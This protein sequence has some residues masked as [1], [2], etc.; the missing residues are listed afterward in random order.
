MVI[1]DPHR[2]ID[3]ESARLVA[4]RIEG[5]RSVAWMDQTHLI[6]RVDSAERRSMQMIDQVCDALDPLG[7]T[8]G[9]VVVLQNANARNGDEMQSLT[10]NCQLAEGQRALGQGKR[11]I[12]TVSPEVRAQFKA[13]QDRNPPKQ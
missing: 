13:M 8:L 2:R 3:P 11:E 4:G 12:D 7:D 5:V 6:V 9:V 1:A 10:R